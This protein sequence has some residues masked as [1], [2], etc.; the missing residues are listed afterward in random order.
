MGVDQAMTSADA[1]IAGVVG[2]LRAGYMDEVARE[3]LAGELE[4]ARAIIRK[5]APKVVS[6]EVRRALVGGPV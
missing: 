2:A 1:M 6:P 4:Q 3:H 5:N